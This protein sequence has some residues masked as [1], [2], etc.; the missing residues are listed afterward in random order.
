MSLPSPLSV[1]DIILLGQIAYK[2]GRAL[3][4]GTKSAPAEF[5]EVQTL[6]FSLKESFDL[7]ARTIINRE[8]E[9]GHERQNA[10]ELEGLPE[11]SN[12]LG[13][14]REVLCYL[15]SFVDK[16]SVLDPNVKAPGAR[17]RKLDLRK[18]WK[19]VAWT[20]E[21]GDIDKLKQTLIAHTNALHIA[22]AAIHGFVVG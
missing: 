7:L 9:D 21:G 3:S 12:I 15:E 18:S 5:A 10:D 17:S 19:K 16:Y 11:L 1:G 6:L 4:S 13:H 8:D 2:V 22:I 14:C 20:R